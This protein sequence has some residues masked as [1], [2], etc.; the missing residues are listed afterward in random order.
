MT[1]FKYRKRKTNLGHI[2]RSSWDRQIYAGK[3]TKPLKV[4]KRRKIA[5]IFPR[6][7]GEEK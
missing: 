6:A 3:E 5:I 2:C 7:Y 4:T 1:T